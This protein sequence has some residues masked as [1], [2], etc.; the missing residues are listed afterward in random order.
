MT[1][2]INRYKKHEK[3][4]TEASRFILYCIK[5]WVYRGLHILEKSV[6][7]RYLL[8]S[9]TF[10]K[11]LKAMRRSGR[12]GEWAA[13]QCEVLLDNIRGRGILADEVYCKRT[14]NGE[15][16]ISNCVK[17][18]LGNGYRLVTVRNGSYL[19]IPFAGTHDETDQWLDRRKHYEFRSGNPAYRKETISA[20]GYHGNSCRPKNEDKNEELDDPYEEQ[21]MTRVDEDMLRQIFMGL[22]GANKQ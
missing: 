9:R 22:Y 20:K 2:T 1:N 17:Y 15:Y 4:L 21:I 3:V 7:I 16:R 11:Q 6:L 14:K 8:C 10:D 5:T 13:M 12:K 19:F 18:D